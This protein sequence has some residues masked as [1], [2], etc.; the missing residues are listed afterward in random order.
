MLRWGMRHGSGKWLILG[1]LVGFV[2]GV[3][4]LAFFFATHLLSE[5]LLTDVAGLQPIQP[6]GESALSTHGHVPEL[7]WGLVILILASGGLVAGW[8]VHRF[9]ASAAGAG[10]EAAVDTFHNKAGRMSLKAAITKFF[11]SIATLGCGGSAGREGPIAMIGAGFGSFIGQKL[12][13]ASRDCRIL[14]AAGIAGGVS[15]IFRAPLAGALIACEVCYRDSDVESE[16]LIPS[17]I[18]AIMAYCVF[19]LGENF[20]LELFFNRTSNVISMFA[21][22]EMTFE[23]GDVL[24][25][26]GYALLA[27][28]CV[29]GVRLQAPL[30]GRAEAGFSR[31]VLPFYWRTAI[32]AALTGVLAWGMYEAAQALG[33]VDP[34]D[35][36]VLSVLGAGYGIVQQIL[37][38]SLPTDGLAVAGLLLLMAIGK[39]MT[40]FCTVCS[41]GSGGLFG[42]SI[43]I[44]GCLG[45]AI[46]HF[47][48][49]VAPAIAPPIPACVIMGMSGYFA[50]AY[51]TPLAA[52]LMVSELTGTYSLLLPTMW[53]VALCF[54]LVGK[55]SIVS[56]QV[57]TLLDSP[58]HRGQFFADV[59]AGIR[60]E[61]VFKHEHEWCS[62]QASTSLREIKE[63][64]TRYQQTVFPVVDQH[65]H[66]V[67]VFSLDDLRSF[68]FD[69]SL[70]MVA[71]ASDVAGDNIVAV[72]GSD[73]LATAI[74]RFTDQ[75]LDELPV[76]DGDGQVQGLLSRREVVAYYNQVV[77]DLRHEETHQTKSYSLN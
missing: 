24:H 39:A 25:L 8:L 16:A 17:F 37:D 49:T 68:L 5:L 62:V 50:A 21:T 75:N 60:V 20:I 66:L 52:M 76:V 28:L 7:N 47:L 6:A 26:V 67:G 40:T 15:A 4:G 41:G 29:A 3:V 18:S 55:Q 34:G 27:L 32:G 35:A 42:P 30:L 71:V 57:D 54:L 59:L 46:G 61:S 69:E 10:M 73:S 11:A 38:N 58:A 63:L 13:L 45:G 31:I 44:G 19:L 65:G 72:H 22:P 14:L 43:V 53:V 64:L 33:W 9:A 12:G 70:E 74:Q 1:G 51:H 77:G 2:T 36:T 23:S 48:Q 56:A